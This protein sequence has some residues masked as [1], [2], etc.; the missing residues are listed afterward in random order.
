M[1]NKSNFTKNLL[2]WYQVFGRK[3]LP[4]QQNMTPYRVWISEIMLQQ[5]QVT[6]V[7]P[8]YQKFIANFPNISQLAKAKQDDILH[9]WT[10]LGYY[11]RA[12]N[13]HRTAQIICTQYQGIFPKKIEEVIALPGIGRSTAGAILSFSR[14]E[15]HPILDGNVK[16]V[17]TR[18]FAIGGWPSK[19]SVENQ[20]WQAA[21]ELTPKNTASQ[22]NQGIMDLGSTICRRS[23]PNCAQCPVSNNCSAYQAGTQG[24]YP[25][26]KPKKVKP[27]KQAHMLVY[28]KTKQQSQEVLLIKRPPTGIWGGLWCFPQY[29]TYQEL[30]NTIENRD[31]LQALPTFRHTFSHYH[32]EIS[33][34]TLKITTPKTQNRVMEPK[35]TLWYNLQ[36]PEKIGLAA[37]TIKILKQLDN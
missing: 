8:Y 16:R 35:P 14:K 21:I 9:L 7:I 25:S 37:A 6:T 22:Y 17:L 23:N 11:A 36:Q 24:Q 26:A 15:F 18:Y 31:A 29:D 1:M 28:Q 13:L 2:E 27:V 34:Y 20:L 10:G 32:L 19:K 4:W 12:R 3:D 30:A 33:P 5:T